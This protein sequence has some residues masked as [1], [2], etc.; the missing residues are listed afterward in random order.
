MTNLFRKTITGVEN[1]IVD[2]YGNNTVAFLAALPKNAVVTGVIVN[3]EYLKDYAAVEV[4]VTVEYPRAV[5]AEG[6][7]VAAVLR[8]VYDGNAIVDAAK[9][10]AIESFVVEYIETA[11]AEV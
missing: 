9:N 5:Y 8:S 7:R 6:I 10:T 4:G 2:T 1:V 11:V 3:G